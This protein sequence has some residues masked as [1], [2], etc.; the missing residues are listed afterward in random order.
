[1]TVED[2]L[3]ALT[4]GLSGTNT[5]PLRRYGILLS[6]LSVKEE[7]RRQGLIQDTTGV[8]PQNIRVIATQSLIMK[9]AQTIIGQYAREYDELP[10]R[11]ERVRASLENLK[12][13]I[14]EGALPAFEALV[15]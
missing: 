9:Q 5:E 8:I 7:A 6:E 15:G 10:A 4:S 14:G 11:Q 12:V 3:L 13:E 1:G 2:A